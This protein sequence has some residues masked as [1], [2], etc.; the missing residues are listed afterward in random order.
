MA[1]VK[2]NALGFAPQMLD[3]PELIKLIKELSSVEITNVRECRM[4]APPVDIERLVAL[5]EPHPTWP[6]EEQVGFIK[7]LRY[8]LRLLRAD[9]DSIPSCRSTF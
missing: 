6:F 8:I 5:V 7:V 1:P 9:L 3:D 4:E 2:N